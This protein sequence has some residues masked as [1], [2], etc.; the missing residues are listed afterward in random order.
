MGLFDYEGSLL[1]NGKEANSYTRASLH[2]RTTVCF[3]D[4][5]KYNLTIRENV[6]T[7]NYPRMD[8][9]ELLNESLKRGGADSIVA[10]FPAG[11]DQHL[12]KWWT[13]PT[14]GEAELPS[15]PPPPP[16]PPPGKGAGPPGGGKGPPGT[17]GMGPPPPLSPKGPPPS[18]PPLKGRMARR[19]VRAQMRDAKGLSGGQWQ[20]IALARAFMR[21][22]EADLVVFEYVSP[23]TRHQRLLC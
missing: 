14:G 15:L 9:G 1:I 19:K 18:M 16:P 5:A 21:S 22:D 2:A 11:V 12:E 4:Y 6:G 17:R 8:D 23:R 3:Q 20:R 13:P 7:G 10:K